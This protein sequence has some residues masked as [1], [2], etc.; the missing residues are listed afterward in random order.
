MVPLREYVDEKYH[1]L[2]DISMENFRQFLDKISLHLEYDYR[3]NYLP[4]GLSERGAIRP[5]DTANYNKCMDPDYFVPY[6][7]I[8]NMTQRFRPS[9]IIH[10]GIFSTIYSTEVEDQTVCVEHVQL[11]QMD[12]FEFNSHQFHMVL[13]D[14]KYMQQ[15][16]DH[17]NILELWGYSFHPDDMSIFYTYPLLHNLDQYIYLLDPIDTPLP[18]DQRFLIC[19][20]IASGLAYLHTHADFP[21]IHTRIC[22]ENIYLDEQQLPKIGNFSFAREGPLARDPPMATDELYEISGF[23]PIEYN[24]WP[25]CLSTKVDVYSYGVTLLQLLTCRVMGDTDGRNIR[26]YVHNLVNRNRS[27]DHVIDTNDQPHPTARTTC[28]RIIYIAYLCTKHNYIVRPEMKNVLKRL[29]D[30][31]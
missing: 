18:F 25:H 15:L 13:K 23:F 2:L 24:A 1:V 4:T 6:Q 26:N 14:I 30:I 31:F 5:V 22:P 21:L 16:C 28:I 8:K 12:F 10:S 20:G 7:T 29:Q 3:K 9:L 19:R 27:L 11:C 17:E